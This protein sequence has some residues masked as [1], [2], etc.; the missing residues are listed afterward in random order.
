MFS[1]A[2]EVNAVPLLLL[3]L[4]LQLGTATQSNTATN[5]RT[6]T[7]LTAIGAASVRQFGA[8]CD[9]VTDDTAAIQAA[10]NCGATAVYSPQGNC[11]IKG[12]VHCSWSGAMLRIFGDGGGVSSGGTQGSVWTLAGPGTLLTYYGASTPTSFTIEGIKF[13]TTHTASPT[14]GLNISHSYVNHVR[15][16]TFEGFA[17]TAG[18]SAALVFTGTP[19]NSVVSNVV[20]CSFAMNYIGVYSPDYELNLL[21]VDGCYFSANAGWAIRGGDFTGRPVYFTKWTIRECLF[22]GNALGDIWTTG[23]ARG[24]TVADNYFEFPNVRPPV[25]IDGVG[26]MNNALLFFGNT[27]NGDPGSGRG[28]IETRMTAGIRAFSNWQGPS[29]NSST[30]FFVRALEAESVTGV[31]VERPSGPCATGLTHCPAR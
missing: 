30:R 15:H 5:F 25:V 1:A 10:L 19:A 20:G 21:N 22:E 11:I 16:V 13:R 6:E 24:L 9:G 29:L 17:S 26:G 31:N 27:F 23:G 28:I 4:P 14:F 7:N 12:N 8:K 2:A 18:S 3:L